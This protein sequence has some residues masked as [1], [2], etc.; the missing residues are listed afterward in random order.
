LNALFG[1]GFGRV[2]ELHYWGS[3]EAAR[4]ATI[5]LRREGDRRFLR[6]GPGAPTY[7]EQWVRPPADGMLAVELEL[8]SARRPAEGP[9]AKRADGRPEPAKPVPAIAGSALPLTVTLCEKWMLTSAR[10]E[11]AKVV[12]DQPAGNGWLR[13]QAELRSFSA[14]PGRPLK[15]TLMAPTAGAGVDIGRVSLR[16]AGGA[17]LLANGDFAAGLARWFWTTDVDPPWHIHSLPLALWFDLGW[18]GVAMWTLALG[19][20]A[21]AALR[22][23]QRG[24]WLAPTALVALTGFL[25]SGLVN[26]LI[27]TP[28][29]LFLLLLLVWLCG[30]DDAERARQK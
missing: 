23:W 6:L 17:E 18:V 3:R 21:V 25:T 12:A 5:H 19:A 27:D 1:V 8:R 29:F 22:R 16:S 15:F 26:T 7:V 4:A 20:A 24:Q 9:A 30:S 14:A 11:S 13:G 10:C 2:P 28:R